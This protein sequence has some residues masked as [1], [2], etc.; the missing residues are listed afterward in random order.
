L[1]AQLD[2]KL[3]YRYRVVQW[4]GLHADRTPVLDPLALVDVDLRR[5][6]IL[7]G[8]L[9]SQQKDQQRVG[10]IDR[11]LTCRSFKRFNR[12]LVGMLKCSCVL[13]VL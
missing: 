7:I 6:Q 11:T 8:R 1:P 12:I 3:V 2:W 9:G 5:M 4:Y 10:V 13:G